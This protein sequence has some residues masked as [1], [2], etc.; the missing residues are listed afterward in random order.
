MAN[1]K[2]FLKAIAYILPS[3][4]QICFLL[5]R[6]ILMKYGVKAVK[7]QKTKIDDQEEKVLGPGKEVVERISA[8]PIIAKAVSEHKF[9]KSSMS[10]PRVNAKKAVTDYDKVEIEHSFQKYTTPAE[11]KPLSNWQLMDPQHQMY[12]VMGSIVGF[13]SILGAQFFK[14]RDIKI[15]GIYQRYFRICKY[16]VIPFLGFALVTQINELSVKKVR[17]RVEDHL[18]KLDPVFAFGQ[19][20]DSEKWRRTVRFHYE[21]EPMLSRTFDEDGNTK[22]FGTY[23]HWKFR[24]IYGDRLDSERLKKV[25]ELITKDYGYGL[26][27]IKEDFYDEDELSWI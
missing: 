21:R 22:L 9:L 17:R 10:T 20:E 8:D 4:N 2:E 24:E 16:A 7:A 6:E 5:A 3:D 27:E 13:A 14:P 18:V 1:E 15:E 11:I 19:Y 23:F 25:S 12:M 26:P